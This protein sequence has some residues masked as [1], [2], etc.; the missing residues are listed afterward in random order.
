MRKCTRLNEFSLVLLA[1][2]LMPIPGMEL[3]VLAQTSA[4]TAGTSQFFSALPIAP[5]G[6]LAPRTLGNRAADVFNWKDFGASGNGTLTPVGTTYGTTPSAWSTYVA[7]DGSTPLS[8][9]T[10]A[11]YGLQF[12]MPVSLTGSSGNG[13]LFFSTRHTCNTGGACWNGLMSLWSDPSN[14]NY[15][16]A[17][18]MQVTS[19]ANCL[20]RQHGCRSEPNDDGNGQPA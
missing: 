7:P 12:S 18:G 2:Q 13:L 5:P 6:G 16:V 15:L 8:W 9:A 11:A 20:G 4:P 19:S 10:N 17:P 1:T 14:R 3:R